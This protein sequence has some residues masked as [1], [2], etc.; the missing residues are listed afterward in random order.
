MSQIAKMIIKD[1]ESFHVLTTDT[2][3][4]I[5]LAAT[6]TVNIQ[7]ALAKKNITKKIKDN[8]ITRNTFTTRQVQFDK[9]PFGL[10]GLRVIHST[11]GITQKAAY[12]ERQEKGG[13]HK[14]E[15]GLK[16]AIPTDIARSGNKRK[17]VTKMYRVNKIRMQKVKGPFKKNIASK[18][19]RQV[20]RAYIA[21][22]TG[23]LIAYNNNL[24]KVT[25]FSAQN[26]NVSFKL[27]QVYNFSKTQTVTPP[28]PFF[29]ASC[30][31]PAADGQKIF[32]SQM[33][34]LQK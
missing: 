13:P 17:P 23:K 32:N 25:R 15:I 20:A 7:A 33:N 9:M 16:L 22:K 30:E 3:K 31:K 19:S 18:K 8:F 28:T 27:K 34:K 6:N 2:K 24:H 11:V 29:K 4:M 1:P 10:Y 26:G 14:P 5:L 12:M 21:F